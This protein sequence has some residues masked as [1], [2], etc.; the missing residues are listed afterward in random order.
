MPLSTLIAAMRSAQDAADDVYD[1][2]DIHRNTG[3]AI[4]IKLINAHN[5]TQAANYSVKVAYATSNSDYAGVYDY[6]IG[7]AHEV[8]QFATSAMATLT[9]ERNERRWQLLKT[10]HALC[11]THQPPS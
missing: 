5:A 7:Y 10:L 6:G 1:A 11:P 9:N 2:Y 4:V 3:R 8:A